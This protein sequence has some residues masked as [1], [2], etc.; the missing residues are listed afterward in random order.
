MEARERIRKR[1]QGGQGNVDETSSM[2][3]KLI[4]KCGPE[5]SIP[6]VMAYD[7]LQAGIDT[8]GETRRNIRILVF[9]TPLT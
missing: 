8:T 7:M 2:L 1:L 3:D 9:P 6:L 5:S 4:I